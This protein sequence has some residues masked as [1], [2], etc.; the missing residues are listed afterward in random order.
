[1]TWIYQCS[2]RF[3]DLEAPA[4]VGSGLAVPMRGAA[5]VNLIE[6]QYAV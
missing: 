1:M 4:E 6:S 2:Q 3:F 5:D